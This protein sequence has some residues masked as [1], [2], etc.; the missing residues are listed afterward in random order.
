MSRLIGDNNAQPGC[1]FCNNFAVAKCDAWDSSA[2]DVCWK[3]ICHRCRRHFAG[4]DSCPTHHRAKIAAVPNAKQS[5]LFEQIQPTKE[6]T[7]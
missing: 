4:F 7:R 5:G 3:K 1:E 2:K 6:V